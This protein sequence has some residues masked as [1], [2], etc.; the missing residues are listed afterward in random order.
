MHKDLVSTLN[1]L[2]VALRIPF[3]LFSPTDLTPSL[4]FVIVESILRIHLPIPLT[5]RTSDKIQATK[6]FLGVLENDILKTDVGLSNVDP[7][8]LARGEERECIFIGELLCRL[9]RTMRGGENGDT[10]L[11]T[12]S[13]QTG[14]RLRS[15]QTREAPD[16]WTMHTQ[17]DQTDI[18][19][20][21]ASDCSTSRD[22]LPRC[23]HEVA[24]SSFEIT[25]DQS[26]CEFTRHSE[27]S[28]FCDCSLHGVEQSEFCECSTRETQLDFTSSSSYCDCDLASS[29]I[30]AAT[31]TPINA[32]GSAPWSSGLAR[33]HIQTPPKR[34][35]GSSTANFNPFHR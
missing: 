17:S 5:L 7:R 3:T 19:I 22:H 12:L 20:D 2:L 16:D 10:I 14:L 13:G 25:W 30:L 4:L 18:R 23:I 1:S 32:A 28:S 15:P 33:D 34:S 21:R 8:K 24:D 11:P 35:A 27:V 6:I 26:T 29:S 31:S 9:G